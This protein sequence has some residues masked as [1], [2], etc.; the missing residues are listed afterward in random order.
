M[1]ALRILLTGGGTGG[2]IYPALTLA[3]AM[4]SQAPAVEFL[5]VGR[6]TGLEA[7]VVQQTGMPYAAIE[8]GGIAGLGAAARLQGAWR[9][10]RGVGQA[11]RIMQRYR[12]AAAIGCGG[13]VSGPV[14]LGARLA[15]VP[16][17]VLEADVNPGMASRI[18]ARWAAAVFVSHEAARPHFPPGTPLYALGMPVRQAILAVSRAQGRTALG[19]G[20]EDRVVL[21]VGGSGGARA[22]HAATVAAARRLLAQPQVQVL[23]VAGYRY[24]DQVARDY[25][26]AGIDLDKPGRLRLVPYLHN[27]P[28]ALAAADL[29]VTRAGMTTLAELTARGVPA[30]I[31]PSPNVARNHQEANARVLAEAGAAVLLR[32]AELSGESLASAVLGLLGDPAAMTAMAAASRSLGRPD[33]AAAIA[34]R[35]LALVSKGRS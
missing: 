26:A 19:Y 8:S 27:M 1:K 22:I 5:Y 11:R 18:A 4:K 17:I 20:P 15:G 14:L 13:Y 31:I 21:I 33:A 9:A 34:A 3:E 25:A 29:A 23:H 10:L 32:E 7:E 35:I 30:V 12:P 16:A 2:H 6:A 28:E 24:Y